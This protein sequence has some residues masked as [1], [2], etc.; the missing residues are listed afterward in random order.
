MANKGMA[1]AER[2][3]SDSLDWLDWC[4]LPNQ[5]RQYGDYWHRLVC[6]AA[7]QPDLEPDEFVQHVYWLVPLA[8]ALQKHASLQRLYPFIH[9]AVLDLRPV[10]DRSVAGESIMLFARAPGHFDATRVKHSSTTGQ[11]EREELAVGEAQHVA[12]AV[13]QAVTTAAA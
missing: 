5:V 6:E 12:A 7:G 9:H 1:E 2:T 10:P 13:A 8:Q 4:D 3:N 11:S